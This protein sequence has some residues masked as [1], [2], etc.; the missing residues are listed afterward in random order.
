MELSATPGVMSDLRPGCLLLGSPL[1]PTSTTNPH[2]AHSYAP[3]EAAL[4]APC[5]SCTVFL[6]PALANTCS[7]GHLL[8]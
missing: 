3:P 6:N 4:L 1:A 7:F 8:S 2:V 5:S